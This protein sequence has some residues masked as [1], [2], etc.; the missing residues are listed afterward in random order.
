M[1]KQD[2]SFEDFFRESFE[3]AEMKPSTHVWENISNRLDGKTRNKPFYW[4]AGSIAASVVLMFCAYVLVYNPFAD[5]VQ[6]V[7]ENHAQENQITTQNNKN[8]TDNKTIEKTDNKTAEINNNQ[9]ITSQVI[10]SQNSTTTN[11]DNKIDVVNNTNS[12]NKRNNQGVISGNANQNIEIKKANKNSNN[13]DLVQNNTTKQTNKSAKTNIAKSNLDKNSDKIV[14]KDLDKN[15]VAIIATPNDELPNNLNNDFHLLKRLSFRE[16]PTSIKPLQVILFPLFNTSS[17]TDAPKVAIKIGTEIFI[18]GSYNSFSP[19]F[20]NVKDD[21][22]PYPFISNDKN[23]SMIY[24]SSKIAADLM[25]PTMISSYSIGFA[26]SQVVY[27]GLGIRGG[28]NYQATSYELQHTKL[29]FYSPRDAAQSPTKPVILQQQ[30]AL[31]TIP[32]SLSY[33]LQ[34][35]NFVYGLHAGVQTD[36]LLQNSLTNNYY[37]IGDHVYNFGSYNSLNFNSLV[38]IRLGYMIT[39]HFSINMEASYRKSLNSVYD[40]PYLQSNPQ[41]IGAGISVGYRF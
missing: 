15:I 8:N 24:D 37:N 20:S 16:F 41:N 30:T 26:I 27:K 9:N 7:V 17:K 39:P 35:G 32:I 10:T 5:Q 11:T 3:G 2:K 38:G 1:K 6:G 31:L 22:K 28:A 25:N 4:W 23:A 14:N 21:V 29:Y 40:T 19:N 34:T 33:Q 13:I 18:I 36:I 12:A